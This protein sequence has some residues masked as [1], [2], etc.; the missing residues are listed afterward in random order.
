MPVVPWVRPSHGI[1]AEGGERESVEAVELVR[2][3]L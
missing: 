1:G 2:L 3:R